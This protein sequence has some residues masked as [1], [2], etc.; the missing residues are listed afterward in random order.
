MD[1]STGRI[2]AMGTGIDERIVALAN[3]LG[4]DLRQQGNRYTLAKVLAERRIF[5]SKR[6]LTYMAR[7]KVDEPTRTIEFSERLEE[8]TS[9]LGGGDADSSPGF[10]YRKEKYRTGRTA[11]EGT[12][13]EQSR[14]F[15]ARYDYRFD[16]AA[17][18]TRVEVVAHETGYGF[19]HHLLAT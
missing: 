8:V 3:E 19:E 11:R 2:E 17:I 1:P 9:G 6:K 14:L 16:Y 15:G 7:I 12:I 4:T 13:E 10:G 5:L 18:R